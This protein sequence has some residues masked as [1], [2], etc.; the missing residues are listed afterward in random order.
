MRGL[1]G[2]YLAPHC[3]IHH[4]P[5]KHHTRALDILDQ[6]LSED[7]DNVPGLM[8]RGYVMQHAKKWEEGSGL[9]HRAAELRPDDLQDG[10]RAREEEAWC[11]VKAHDPDTGEKSLVAIVELLDAEEGREAD[12]ARCWWRLGKSRWEL[13]GT[14]STALSCLRIG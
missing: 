3:Q 5:P 6:V 14:L 13:G 9:F 10:L 2:I 8:S 11:K 1:R 12:K 7:P 4:F